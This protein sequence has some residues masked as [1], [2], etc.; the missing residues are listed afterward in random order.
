[1]IISLADPDS[2]PFLNLAE[3]LEGE[4]SAVC[5]MCVSASRCEY[6]SAL[7]AVFVFMRFNVLCLYFSSAPACQGKADNCGFTP[8]FITTLFLKGKK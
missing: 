1:L 6:G 8:V 5:T 2:N 3:R 4:D 7:S